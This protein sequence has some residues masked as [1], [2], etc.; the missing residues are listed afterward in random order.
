MASDGKD[1]ARDYL[2][3]YASLRSILSQVLPILL[4]T[5]G[6]SILAGFLFLEMKDSLEILPGLL[7][8]IP[9]IMGTR[10]SI[11]GAF[12]ARIATGLHLGIVEPTFTA[13]RNVNNA[14]VAAL[15]NSVAISIGIAL[16]AY[17]VLALL[18][19]EAIPVWALVAISLIAG[20]ISGLALI[21][22]VIIITYS[23]FR[24][25]I[26][27]DNLVGPIVTVTGDIFSIFA[28]L[29]SA[30]IILVIIA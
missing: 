7:A 29:I 25:G 24:H 1:P 3:R 21:G 23:G 28:L 10:G 5:L 12:G 9:A 17:S 11:Y 8:M 30:R 15:I 19:L 22:V 27:P 13:N 26:D 20:V 6:A 2:E 18:G 16:L 4:L 14:I